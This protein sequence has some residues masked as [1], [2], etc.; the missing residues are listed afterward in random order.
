M[1]SDWFLLRSWSKRA[2]ITATPTKKTVTS[3]RGNATNPCVSN[4]SKAAHCSMIILSPP[5]SERTISGFGPFGL[6]VWGLC[7]GTPSKGTN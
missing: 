7:Y 1:C 4:K 2:L 5:K 3:F 6:R